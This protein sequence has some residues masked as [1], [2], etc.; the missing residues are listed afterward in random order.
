MNIQMPGMGSPE[1][2]VTYRPVEMDFSVYKSAQSLVETAGALTQGFLGAAGEML[3][4]EDFQL[5]K[6]A[7]SAVL[8]ASNRSDEGMMQLLDSF[9]SRSD[10]SNFRKEGDEWFSKFSSE[11]LA[12]APERARDRISEMLEAKKLD[13]GI[14]VAGL[15]ASKAREVSRQHTI[16]AAKIQTHKSDIP[17]IV[18]VLDQGFLNGDFSWNEKISLQNEEIKSVRLTLYDNDVAGNPVDYWHKR[19]AGEYHL[20]DPSVLYAG[21][22]KAEMQLALLRDQKPLSEEQTAQIEAGEPVFEQFEPR[23]GATKQE[24]KWVEYYNEHGNLD[25]FQNEIQATWLQEIRSAPVLKTKEEQR[26]WIE[27]LSKKYSFYNANDEDIRRMASDK[28]REINGLV[29]MTQRLNV[30]DFLK[31]V[32]RDHMLGRWWGKGKREEFENGI[33]QMKDYVQVRLSAWSEARRKDRDGK[34]PTYEDQVM[35][36]G[37]FASQYV[38]EQKYNEIKDIDAHAKMIAGSLR[39]KDLRGNEKASAGLTA[40]Q[41][42]YEMFRKQNQPYKPNAF[43]YVT[44]EDREAPVVEVPGREE[45]VYVPRKQ[46]DELV[47][48]LGGTPYVELT[49]PNNANRKF[50]VLGGYDGAD[51]GLQVTTQARTKMAKLKPETTVY[52]FGR[53]NGAGKTEADK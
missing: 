53:F 12:G 42:E 29:D 48:R 25:V 36:A 43:T 9:H 23:Y 31:S 44:R 32:S 5:N 18:N 16:S 28:M 33:N 41:L 52:R 46:Y 34:E 51:V 10:T 27:T 50:K 39:G 8:D 30:G 24:H 22:K 20:L 19:E 26:E 4:L 47:G 15:S 21:D 3:E 11:T 49:F 14:Q 7:D 13:F 40:Q 2:G 6:E 45:G 38:K 1:G 37:V 35:M 17:G